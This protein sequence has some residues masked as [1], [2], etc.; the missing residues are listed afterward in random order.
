MGS[1]SG[2]GVRAPNSP[3]TI[4]NCP[5]SSIVAMVA[6]EIG[7]F[8]VSISILLT[9]ND[10]DA[11][12]VIFTTMLN[13]VEV[14]SESSRNIIAN[15]SIETDGSFLELTIDGDVLNPVVVISTVLNVSVVA[16]D[17]VD[18]SEPCVVPVT[19]E[20]LQAAEC[21]DPEQV[22]SN[23]QQALSEST[24]TQQ[25]FAVLVPLVVIEVSIANTISNH[26]IVDD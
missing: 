24:V 16:S 3:P 2:S 12:Q 22:R 6:P 5:V 8:S 19:I 18:F 21:Q 11:D 7:E 1:G 13:S 4:E 25:F 17:G 10:P 9:A 26:T 20:Y 14:V 23:D 15:V